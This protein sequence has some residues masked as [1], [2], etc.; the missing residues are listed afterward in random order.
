MS[1]SRQWDAKRPEHEN[2]GP[3][4][5]SSATPYR[6]RTSGR[7]SWVTSTPSRGCRRWHGARNS[8]SERAMGET[9]SVTRSGL[10][11]GPRGSTT[12]T[13]LACVSSPAANTVR[14]AV[15]FPGRPWYG[16]TTRCS[17]R[18]ECDVSTRSDSANDAERISSGVPSVEPPSELIMTV[19]K[20]G[21]SRV[22]LRWT[23]RTTF[24]IVAALFRVGRPTRMSTCPTAIN[25]RSNSSDSAL[26]CSTV[27]AAPRAR[28][29]GGR[30]QTPAR[31]SAVGTSRNHTDPSS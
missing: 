5:S 6:A 21:K 14:K 2:S 4:G 20:R 28:R 12:T 11:V 24:A 29:S 9:S 1:C 25:C 10:V 15:C 23:A 8:T 16:A 26:C 13:T 31:A 7:A 3:S 27:S 18:N 22:K 30:R 17:V 19:R